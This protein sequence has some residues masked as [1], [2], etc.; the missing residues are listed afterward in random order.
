MCSNR[1]DYGVESG[2]FAGAAHLTATR[3]VWDES[4]QRANDRHEQKCDKRREFV[5]FI[6][7]W[8]EIVH[9]ARA[10]E[11][12]RSWAYGWLDEEG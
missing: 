1:R 10:S 2:G 7:G 4:E 6:P 12:G 3:Q 5:L 11:P 8:P 9:S